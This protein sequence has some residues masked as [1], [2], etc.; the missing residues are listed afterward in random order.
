MVKFVKEELKGC[1]E[2]SLARH[3]RYFRV[4]KPTAAQSKRMQGRAKLIFAF[5]AATEQGRQ[6]EKWSSTRCSRRGRRWRW[7]R[8][9]AGNWR[10]RRCVWPRACSSERF[11][12]AEAAP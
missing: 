6:L 9:T 4:I 2:A 3:N 1:T 7:V 8:H 11:S 10:G 12:E 5:S